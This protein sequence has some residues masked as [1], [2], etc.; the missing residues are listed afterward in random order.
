MHKK[1]GNTCVEACLHS[2]TPTLEHGINLHRKVVTTVKTGSKMCFLHVLLAQKGG[3]MDG[4]MQLGRN[5]ITSTIT[6]N[7][8]PRFCKLARLL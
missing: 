6:S 5:S 8:V 3:I 2:S 7:L 4:V 1:S